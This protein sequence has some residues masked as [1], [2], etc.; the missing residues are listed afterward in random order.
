MFCNEVANNH[1]NRDYQQC[2]VVASILALLVSNAQ[3][4]HPC[5]SAVDY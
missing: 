4:L 5:L 3:S 1:R 2:W